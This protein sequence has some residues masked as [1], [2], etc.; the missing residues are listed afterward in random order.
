MSSY[1][2]KI[3]NDKAKSYKVVTYVTAVIN[4][5]FFGYLMFFMGEV[6]E[7]SLFFI[8]FFLSIISLLF[9]LMRQKGNWLSGFRIEIY[10]IVCGLIWLVAGRYGLGVLLMLF[11][12][13]GFVNNKELCIQFS[14]DGILYPSFPVKT[15]KWEDVDFVI[16]K[17]DILSIELKKNQ[18]L[19]F[20]LETE[21]ASRIDVQA[22]NA[23]CVSQATT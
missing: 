4:L 16:L 11:A 13:M 20:T 1:S 21:E 10:F 18:L 19:Q 15:Y 17:D 12:F 8:G 7:K 14:E 23:F 2:I 5:V 22:F 9:Y 6:G 3:P